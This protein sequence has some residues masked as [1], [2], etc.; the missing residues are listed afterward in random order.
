M[1]KEIKKEEEKI[2]PVEDLKNKNTA[3]ETELTKRE[4]LLI[5][6]KNFEAMSGKSIGAPQETKPVEETPKGICLT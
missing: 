4:Q 2:D 1:D 6:L 3:L 5:R